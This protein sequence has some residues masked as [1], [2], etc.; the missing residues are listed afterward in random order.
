M[1]DKTVDLFSNCSDLV[2]S[3]DID[4]FKELVNLINGWHFL[5][6]VSEE[7][8]KLFILVINAEEEAIEQSHWILLDI[9]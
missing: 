7:L 8:N 3:I 9:S 5:N 6:D 1:V 4:V 2:N